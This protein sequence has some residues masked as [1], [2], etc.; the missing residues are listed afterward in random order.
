MALKN[1]LLFLLWGSLMLSLATGCAGHSE[2]NNRRIEQLYKAG[3]QYIAQNR[4][5][6]ALYCFMEAEKLLNEITDTIICGNLYSQLGYLWGLNKDYDAAIGYYEKSIHFYQL[7][8]DNNRLAWSLLDLGNTLRWKNPNDS[9]AFSCYDHARRLSGLSDTVQGALFMRIGL[10]YHHKSQYDSALFYLH[11]SVEPQYFVEGKSVRML[12]LGKTYYHMNCFDSASHYLSHAL[13]FPVSIR[14]RSG[15]YNMLYKVAVSEKDS[16]RMIHYGNLSRLCKDSIM[17]KEEQTHAK[18]HAYDKNQYKALNTHHEELKKSHMF[19]WGGTAIGIL[20]LT[21]W[22]ISYKKKQTGNLSKIR[23]EYAELEHKLQQF[24]KQK[25]LQEN[26]LQK[27]MVQIQAYMKEEQKI[28]LERHRQE[29]IANLKEI[30]AQAN[31]LYFMSN[32]YKDFIVNSYDKQLH[33]ND[34]ERFSILFNNEFNGF[35]DKVNGFYKRKLPQTRQ[36][37]MF[38]GLLLL[39]APQTE[40]EVVLGYTG[41]DSYKKRMKNLR[42]L[43]GVETVDELML[44]LIELMMK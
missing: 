7:A 35:A 39:E 29:Y 31:T 30:S 10:Y 21:I 5:D 33:V 34:W 41:S 26:K 17:Q 9:N 4:N 1:K 24:N 13:E 19:L 37:V 25:K 18:L 2:Q 3:R 32:E 27:R 14:Q 28:L 40:I 43:F 20:C 38:C 8:D 16:A 11:K 6:S 23:S 42:Q 36:S 12:F 15:C 22:G 44:F